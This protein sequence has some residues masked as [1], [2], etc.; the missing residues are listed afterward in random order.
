[1]TGDVPAPADFGRHPALPATSAVAA[2]LFAVVVNGLGEEVGW[3]GFALPHLQRRHSPLRAVGILTLVWAAWHA[4]IIGALAAFRD[5]GLSG[6]EAA[7]VFTLGIGCLTVVLVW[8]VNRSGSVLIAAIAHG[9]YNMVAG[10]GAAQGA[11]GTVTTV[12]IMV[13]AAVL[14]VRQLRR[15]APDPGPL[16][17]DG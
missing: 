2:W 6:I 7:P 8:F 5:R 1:M 15:R 12:L 17:P 10:T 14:V 11:V 13:G 16:A 9:S 4:P 3:R